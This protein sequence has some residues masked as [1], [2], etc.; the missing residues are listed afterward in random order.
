MRCK[1]C[2]K[3]DAEYHDKRDDIY[4]CNTCKVEVLS[5][6]FEWEEQPDDNIEEKGSG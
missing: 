5:V 2:N 1:C 4:L 3:R 6:V